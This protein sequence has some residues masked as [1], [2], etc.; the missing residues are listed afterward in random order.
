MNKFTPKKEDCKLL[1]CPVLSRICAF[2]LSDYTFECS[3]NGCCYNCNERENICVIEKEDKFL[4]FVK[5][6]KYQEL[7]KGEK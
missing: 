6:K 2:H 3:S 4:E 1:K 7:I 5:R